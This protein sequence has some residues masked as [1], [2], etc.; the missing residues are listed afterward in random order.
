MKWIKCSDR[1]PPVNKYVL[2]Y[3]CGGNW[4]HS[5]DDPNREVVMRVIEDGTHNPNNRNAG[6]GWDT[7]GPKHHFAADISHWC[8]IPSA[9][10]PEAK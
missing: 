4:H 3:Y 10:E 2:G 5:K 8:E 1:L 7:F 6:Y 9:P